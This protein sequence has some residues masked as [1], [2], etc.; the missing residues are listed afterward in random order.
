MSFAVGLHARRNESPLFPL[1]RAP[2]P[3]APNPRGGAA[4][5]GARFLFSK[6]YAR[7]G[8]VA[9]LELSKPWTALRA[10]DWVARPSKQI[11][12]AVEEMR[13]E[14]VRRARAAA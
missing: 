11:E 13:R 1:A 2:P 9:P 3:K 7:W 12:A 4:E 10:V 6:A 8:A 14:R 5:E